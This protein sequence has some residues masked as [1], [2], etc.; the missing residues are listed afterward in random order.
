MEAA[1]RR[2]RGHRVGASRTSGGPRARLWRRR[3]RTR[4]LVDGR[5]VFLGRHRARARWRGKFSAG[6]RRRSTHSASARRSDA[7][8]ASQHAAWIREPGRA[9]G[10]R[11]VPRVRGARGECGEASAR[12][13]SR[14][15]LRFLV[16][17]H[18]PAVDFAV[19]TPVR[20]VLRGRRQSA[21]RRVF[22]A[23]G[24]TRR[25]RTKRLSARCRP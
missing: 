11:A 25:A 21:G 8:G 17:V 12:R 3:D 7:G 1:R 4:H 15:R 6:R 18:P 13:M 2:E 24:A 19:A 23:F 10:A 5:D 20:D 16:A 14:D 22:E 9:R